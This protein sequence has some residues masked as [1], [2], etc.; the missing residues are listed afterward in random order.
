M[1]FVSWR[2][3]WFWMFFLVRYF[4]RFILDVIKRARVI[5][6]LFFCKKI[7]VAKKSSVYLLQ[8]SFFSK[9]KNKIEGGGIHGSK[10]E[11]QE[12]NSKE[13][14][15]QEEGKEE[16]VSSFFCYWITSRF[17]SGRYCFSFFVLLKHWNVI[18]FL[19]LFLLRAFLAT[20]KQTWCVR[21]A[22]FWRGLWRS[23]VLRLERR[24]Q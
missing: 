8:R 14:D 19:S 21:G 9:K 10:K 20:V 3:T 5:L 1:H 18:L 24:F 17:F 6:K 11:S 22:I 23:S 15:D 12:G 4:L 7:C 2:G 16:V 13:E